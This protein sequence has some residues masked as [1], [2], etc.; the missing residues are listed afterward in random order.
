MTGLLHADIVEPGHMHL[1]RWQHIASVYKELG[2]LKPNLDLKG[3]LYDANPL[4]K[5]LT[6]LF[7]ALA[8]LTLV[9]LIVGGNAYYIFRTNRRLRV[10]DQRWQQLFEVMPMALVVSDPK[11][12]V[13][14]WNA[15][16]CRIFGWS[17]EE[18]IGRNV[19]ELLVPADQ[20]EH[21]HRV[22]G[23]TIQQSQVTESLNRNHTKGGDVITCEWRNAL[24]YDS[25]GR[26]AGAISLGAD[27]S[28]RL[29]IQQ[30]LEEAKALAERRLADHRQFLAMVAHEFRSPLAAIDATVQV[31]EL[32]CVEQC[33]SPEVIQRIRRGVKRLSGF[34][35]NALAED[36]LTRLYEKGLTP[37]DDVI[38][39]ADF[40]A[41]LVR[42]IRHEVSRQE[43]RLMASPDIG[44]IRGDSSL[45]RILFSNLLGNACKY[46]PPGTEVRLRATSDSDGALLLAVEDAG[47]GIDPDD[48][49][50]VCHRYYRGKNRAQA[51][52]AGLGLF[53]VER[54]VQLHHG[55]LHIACPPGNG[56]RVS[57]RLP[58]SVR[59]S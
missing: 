18:A 51:T 27:V 2:M 34:I 42:Q 41:S 43:I 23:A 1:G 13:T 55:E 10:S 17:A 53:L 26:M 52:G 45:L 15:A 47:P 46:S 57:I 25:D 39:L 35:D 3:F 37:A 50:K 11:A 36:R 33:A 6:W 30:R 32:S 21:V 44:A 49:D 31:L 16:A 38:D 20:R 8:G 4:P 56:T 22:L 9:L 5:D 40:L 19:Y 54:I 14:A 28:E 59:I 24:Y 12:Q 29:S 48:L 58:P 7:A